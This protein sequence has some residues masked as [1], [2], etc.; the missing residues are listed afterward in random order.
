MLT[1]EDLFTHASKVIFATDNDPNGRRLADD[2]IG[3]IGGGKCWRVTWPEDC[4]DAN[5]VLM[6]HGA[7]YLADMIDHA[8][9]EPV[10]GVHD[11]G[12]MRDTMLHIFRHGREK[13]WDFGY[14]V[15]DKHYTVSPGYMTIVTGH[16]GHGKSTALDQLLVRLAQRHGIHITMY[17]PEQRPFDFHQQVLIEQY[18]GM[19]FTDGPNMR[20]S[21]AEMLKANEWIAQHFS[22]I[23]PEEPTVDTILELIR[24]QVYRTGAKGVV[25]DPWNELEHSRPSNLS[26]TE[27]VSAVLAK[28]RRFAEYHKLH[29]WLVAHPTKMQRAADGSEQVPGLQDVSGSANFRNK[30][31][32]GLT[33]YRDSSINGSAVD[34]L[35][36][37]SKRI[38][39]AKIGRVQFQWNPVNKRLTEVGVVS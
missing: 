38:D 29:L 27:Y 32:F 36:T 33:V 9:P 20:M 28:I 30:A 22:F 11:G 34:I 35:V 15:F 17:S 37:K 4:K 13:G 18:T 26:E 19:P 12:T 10:E 1:C 3:R 2:M 8:T 31:D 7:A 16:A 24:V 14:P 25:I 21:E 5:D 23:A 39:L 6:K